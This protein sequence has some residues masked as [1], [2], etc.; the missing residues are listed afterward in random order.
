MTF[1]LLTSH[2]VVV[3]VRRSLLENMPSIP[4]FPIEPLKACVLASPNDAM[5][6]T[7][8]SPHTAILMDLLFRLYTELLIKHF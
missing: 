8:V 3:V 6:A 7:I 1:S 4:L 2:F 5:V